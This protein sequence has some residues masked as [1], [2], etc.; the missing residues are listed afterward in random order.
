VVSGCQT[1][2]RGLGAP[3]K[4]LEATDYLWQRALKPEHFDFRYGDSDSDPSQPHDRRATDKA[5]S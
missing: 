5:V 4:R 2:G 3:L 1:L